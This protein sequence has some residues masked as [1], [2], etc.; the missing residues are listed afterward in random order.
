MGSSPHPIARP[1]PA[2]AGVCLHPPACQP[3]PGK[4][5]FFTNWLKQTIY[6]VDNRFFHVAK[7]FCHVEKVFRDMENYLG[8]MEKSLG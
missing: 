1:V 3:E 5:G 4:A 7:P 2:P 6:D 8:Q